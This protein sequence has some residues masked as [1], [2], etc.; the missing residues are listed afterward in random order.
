[1]GRPSEEKVPR[2]VFHSTDTGA[3]PA[4]T[5]QFK[6]SDSVKLMTD[7][8]ETA[9]CGGSGEEKRGGEKEGEVY[10]SKRNLVH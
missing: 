4:S 7:G 2:G 6:S 9:I 8:A 3:V 5:V 1:M 10:S